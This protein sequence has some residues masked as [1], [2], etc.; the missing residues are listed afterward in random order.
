LKSDDEQKRKER[1]E[2][3]LGQDQLIQVVTLADRI[4]VVGAQ[5][6]NA[7]NLNRV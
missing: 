1:M 2:S 4:L 5:F 7:D 6:I 3:V